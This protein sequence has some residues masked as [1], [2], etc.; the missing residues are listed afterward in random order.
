MPVLLETLRALARKGACAL[1]A[2]APVA[3]RLVIGQMLFFSGQGKLARLPEIVSQFH[4]WGVPLPGLVAP[5][6]ATI[7]LVGGLMLF[8][9]L[10][11]RAAALLLM[12]VLFGAFTTAHAGELSHAWRIWDSSKEVPLLN[13]IAAVPVF[14]FL[15]WLAAYGPGW[16]SLDRL[17][18]R[19]WPAWRLGGAAP[20]PS[21][22]G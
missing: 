10:G 15:L 5:A 9:G 18:T 20:A 11:T 21:Q 2:V 22:P 17:V 8:F 3:T 1:T 19:F 16:L 14:A 4:D 6:T 13:D 7:E 12:G